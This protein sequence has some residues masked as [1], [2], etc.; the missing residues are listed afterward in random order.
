MTLTLE[1]KP[2]VEEAL[3]RRAATQGLEV[4][5]YALSLLEEAAELPADGNSSGSSAIDLIE[6]FAP[7]RGLNLER[8]PDLGRDIIL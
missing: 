4:T 3:A 5:E 2:E 7:L 1:I 6:L 8:D